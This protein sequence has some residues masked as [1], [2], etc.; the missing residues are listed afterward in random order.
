MR[1]IFFAAFTALLAGCGTQVVP[2]Q[3]T[4][5]KS[6]DTSDSKRFLFNPAENTIVEVDNSSITKQ[7]SLSGCLFDIANA[8]L[9]SEV[10]GA[11][12]V[13]GTGTCAPSKDTYTLTVTMILEKCNDSA[14]AVCY[15][16]KTGQPSPKTMTSTKGGR[17]YNSDLNSF[18]HCA[19]SSYY[20]G[21][22]TFRAVNAQG[23]TIATPLV[24]PVG[25][26]SYVSCAQ[27]P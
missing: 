23:V 17:W 18:T 2:N 16:Y 24:Q 20:R 9:S 10:P 21:R 12:K 27:N 13:N 11:V 15:Q 6:I 22:L 25:N 19:I 3:D 14:G 7:D 1:K 4:S 8:H 5:T 26:I